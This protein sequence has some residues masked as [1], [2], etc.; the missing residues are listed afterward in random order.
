M[1]PSRDRIMPL[2]DDEGE[3]GIAVCRVPSLNSIP[4]CCPGVP[5]RCR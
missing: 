5:P 4:H 3:T 1:S 2:G